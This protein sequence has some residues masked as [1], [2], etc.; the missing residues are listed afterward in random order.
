MPAGTRCRGLLQPATAE[1]HFR[2]IVEISNS[3]LSLSRG[4]YWLARAA[5]AGGPGKASD[6]YARAAAYPATF[7][8]QLASAKL[9]RNAL[10]VTYPSP[11]R[12]R[13]RTPSRDREPVR[14]I[15]RLEEVGYDWRAGIIYRA[16]ARELKSPASWRS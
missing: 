10:D 9:G 11:T 3:P 2:R 7:Y 14:A 12:G 13:T 4:Y 8:G 16:L 1:R 15:K 6:Y 5:E